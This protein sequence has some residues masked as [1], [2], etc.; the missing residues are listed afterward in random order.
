ME[1]FA[2]DSIAGFDSVEIGGFEGWAC[3][4]VEAAADRGVSP[5]VGDVALAED[6]CGVEV[7]GAFGW[8]DLF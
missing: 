2:E 8:F 7:T 1:E 4:F 6:I 3:D 5:G